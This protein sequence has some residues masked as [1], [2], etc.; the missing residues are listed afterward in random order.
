MAWKANASTRKIL[1]GFWILEELNVRIEGVPQGIEV[2]TVY[3]WD[4]EGQRLLRCTMDNADSASVTEVA[5]TQDGALVFLEGMR[6]QDFFLSMRIVLRGGEDSWSIAMERGFNGDPTFTYGEGTFKRMSEESIAAREPAATALAPVELVGNMTAAK[7]MTGHYKMEGWIIPF[8][9]MERM[10]LAATETARPIL[11]GQVIES[12]VIGDEEVTGMHFEGRSFTFWKEERQSYTTAWFDNMG[13]AE[14]S[15]GRPSGKDAW[16][17]TRAATLAG[18]PLVDRS[19]L[20]FEK[21]NLKAVY[22]DRAVG[23]DEPQRIFEATYSA[24]E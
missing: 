5:R 24:G 22:T 13:N 2:K 3:G 18:Q 16:V 17:M 20:T 6:R 4:E 23:T 10:P 1:G 11:G 19:V 14:I 9:G 7:P 15:E 21:G 8:P 12:R